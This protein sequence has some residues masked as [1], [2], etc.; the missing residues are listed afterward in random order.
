MN[1]SLIAAENSAKSKMICHEDLHTFHVNTVADHSYFIPFAKAQDPF[2]LRETSEYFELLNGDWDF[3]YYDSIIDLPDDFPDV[4]AAGTIPVPSNWQLHGYDKAQYTNIFYPLTFDPPYVEDE[5]PVGVYGRDYEYTPDGLQRLLCFEGVDS[6]LYLYIN[7]TFVGYSQV[8]HHTSEFDI[9][10][11]LKP[12]NNRITVAVLKHCDGT[13]LED[14]DKFRLSGIFR[15]VYVLRRPEKH[16]SDYRILSDYDP[17]T[18]QGHFE[19]RVTDAPATIHLYDGEQ[20][21]AEGQA[22]PDAPF[23]AT[24]EQVRPWSAESPSLYQVI[25]ETDTEQIGEMVGFR[26]ITIEEGIFKINGVHITILG[27]NRH[28]SYPDTG[29]YASRERMRADLVQMKQHNINAVRTSHYPNA[30]EFYQLTDEL[31][32]YVIDEADLETH[33]CVNVY[34]D[35]K[36]SAPNAYNGIALIAQDPAFLDAILDRERLLVT[37]DVNRPSVVIWSLGNEAGYGENMRR[38]ALLIKSMDI[39]RPVHYESTHKLDDTSDD[40]LD[41]VSEMYTSPDGIRKFLENKEE[42]RPFILC[43]YC[44]AMGNGPGDLEEY[45]KL[46]MTNERLMGG[47][48]WEWADHAVILGTTEDGK[49]KYGYGGDSGELHHD[50]NFCMDALCYPDRTPHTGLLELKQVYRPVRVSKTDAAGAFTLQSFLA[51]TDAGAFLNCRYEITTDGVVVKEGNTDFSV[52]PMGSTRLTI[53]EAAEL[54]AGE[55][56]IRFV[57]TVRNGYGLYHEGDAICFEQLKLQDGDLQFPVPS[58]DTPEITETPLEIRIKAGAV[59]YMFNK[60]TACFEEICIDGKNLLTRPMQ[61]NFFRAPVDNDVMK[62]DWYSAHIDQWRTKVYETKVVT[63][64]HCAVITVRQSFGWNVNQPFAKMEAAYTID[65]EGKLTITC[66]AETSNKVPFLPRF[67]LRLF[68][69]ADYN[70]VEYYGYGPYESY[71]D[72]HQASYVG[73]FKTS[74]SDLYEPYIRPQENGSHYGCKR[75]QITDGNHRLTFVQ[76]EGFSFNASEYTQEELADKKHN[77]ELEKCGDTVLC[78]DFQMAGVGSAAC[79]PALAECY[80]IP[81][82]NLSGRIVLCP[83]KL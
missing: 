20:L 82:P 49:P 81:L 42:K 5:V 37:R 77:F 76:P 21:L 27:A 15:D 4:K 31:G 78:V 44:H 66:S 33:G 73:T 56:Y 48:V 34:N 62:N 23:S 46:F 79:G 67:G 40:V 6:C 59:S 3:T 11:Y 18:G 28:D 41:M 17:A 1:M 12:G 60:R 43:E 71:I 75:M 68:L 72:K 70:A 30:P 25:L 9:T 45:R 53:P 19:I 64:N 57:F 8:A 16:L 13:Y 36:W 29:Y 26:R 80:R 22:T 52:A 83:E 24:L 39:T 47:L 38:G 63:E 65:G 55:S 58:G 10:G 69:P 2:G 32:L 35:L 7:G 50:G 54:P 14:Q 74:I 61:Y 51:F